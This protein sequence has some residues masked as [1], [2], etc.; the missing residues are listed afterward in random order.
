[1]HHV[2]RWVA[3][4][5]AGHQ[6]FGLALYSQLNE[7]LTESLRRVREGGGKIVKETTAADGG[8]VCA[9]VE[10]PVGATLALV[11]EEMSQSVQLRR[12]LSL[13][14]LPLLAGSAPPACGQ[15][16]STT[17]GLGD[18]S[19]NAADSFS[20]CLASALWPFA[21]SFLGA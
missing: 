19:W 17:S 5:W 4:I 8:C 1:M 2:H 15:P 7:R 11:Q 13:L 20:T 18:L 3:P 9:V 10:D 21:A 12:L 16:A 6:T 14:A